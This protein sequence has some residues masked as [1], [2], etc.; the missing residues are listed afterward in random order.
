[1]TSFIEKIPLFILLYF[2]WGGYSSYD[3]FTEI[4]NSYQEKIDKLNLVLKKSQKDFGKS[5]KFCI[6]VMLS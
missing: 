4:K 6:F 1:M 5:K 2:C 3:A